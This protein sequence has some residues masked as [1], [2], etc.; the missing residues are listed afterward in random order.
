MAVLPGLLPAVGKAKDKVDIALDRGA[1][2]IVN[3]QEADG[4]YTDHKDRD[5]DR[6]GNAHKA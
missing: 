4:P 2:Y 6:N 1:R 3:S 5:S